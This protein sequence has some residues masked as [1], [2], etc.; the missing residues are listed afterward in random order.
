MKPEATQPP[1]KAPQPATEPRQAPA[2][3]R[4]E[5]TPGWRG[6]RWLQ[7]LQDSLSG[8]VDIRGRR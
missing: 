6:S 7:G 4:L 2:Q 8:K 1:E 5:E 3:G